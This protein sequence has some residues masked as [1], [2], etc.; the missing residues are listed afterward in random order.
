MT[1]SDPRSE[2]IDTAAPPADPPAAATGAPVTPRRA[3]RRL[4]TAL[5][6]LLLLGLLALLLAAPFSATGTR[7]LLQHLPGLT[8]QE[9]DG[10]LLGDFSAHEVRLVL[11]ARQTLVLRDLGWQGLQWQLS[12]HPQLHLHT[13]QIGLIDLQGQPAQSTPL[14][15][16]QQLELPFGVQIEQIRIDRLQTEALRQQPLQQLQM[17]LQLQSGAAAHHRLDV[18]Q[19]RWERVQVQGHIDLGAAA[20]L[21]L[22]AELALRPALTGPVAAPET[23]AGPPEQPLDQDWQADL[24]ATGTLADFALDAKLQA[25]H[26]QL[27]GVAQIRPELPLPLDRLAL[28]L[29][30]FD[31]SA[32]S[33]A[34][35]QTALTGRISAA[36]PQSAN[37]SGASASSVKGLPLRLQAELENSRAARIDQHG[38]PLRRLQIGLSSSLDQPQAGHIDTFELQL[39]SSTQEAGRWSGRGR[40]ALDGQGATRHLALA[41]DTRIEQLRPDQLDQ[42]APPLQIAGPLALT[43]RE[44]LPKAADQAAGKT[45]A[46]IAPPP[47][48]A[49]PASEPWPPAADFRLDQRAIGI[50]ADLAGRVTSSPWP[51]VRLQLHAAASAGRLLVQQLQA[52]AETARLQ[53]QGRIDHDPQGRWHTGLQ[54]QLRAFDPVLWWPGEP[55]S[56]WR[57]G[58]HRLDGDLKA[59]LVLPA[60]RAPAA[61][62]A[63]GL[64]RLAL[65]Q[66]Q[67]ALT[68]RPSQIAGLPLSGALTLSATA[69]RAPVQTQLDLQLGTDSDIGHLRLDG[70][71]D[72][73][74]RDDRWQ[75]QWQLP[76]LHRLAPWL[77][78]LQDGT[79]PSWQ[80]DSQ[81]ELRLNG[82]W[83]EWRSDGR[84]DSTALQPAPDLNLQAL[85]LRWQA[86]SSAEDPLQLQL[87]L[88]EARHGSRRLTDLNLDVQGRTDAHHLS[89][90]ALLPAPAEP[91]GRPGPLTPLQAELQADGGWISRDSLSGWQ[92]RLQQLM[93]REAA[94]V[95]AASAATPSTP[96]SPLLQAGPAMLRLM[97]TDHAALQAELGSTRL[98]LL[99]A[100]VSLQE[101]RWQRPAGGAPDQLALQATLEPLTVAPLLARAQPGFGWRGNLQVA[102][103]LRM[104]T[105]SSGLHASA[106]LRRHEGDLVVVDPDNPTTPLQRLGLD[107]LNLTLRA[108][109]GLWTLQQRISGSSLGTL[110]GTQTV[111]TDPH[112]L[113][114]TPEARLDGDLDL[115][116]ARLGQWGRW[117]PAGWR[118][119]GRIDS[120]V[121]LGGQLKAPEFSGELHGQQLGVRNVLQGVN[122]HGGELQLRLDGNAATL[123]HFSVQAGDGRL[124]ASGQL[125]LDEN[126]K[127]DLELVAERF[128][129]L[130]RVDRHVS[131]SGRTRLQLDA[132]TLRLSGQLRADAGRIDISRSEAPGLGND[133]EVQRSAAVPSDTDASTPPPA[134]ARRSVIDLDLDLGHRFQ[135]VG[136]GIQTLLTGQLHLDNPDGKLA[137]R[138]DIRTDDGQYA[139]YGQKLVIDRGVISFLGSPDNPRLDIIATR[140]DLD[141]V[142]V[143]VAVSGTAQNPRVRL[144]SEPEMGNTDKLSWLLLGRASDGL[145]R[146]D[147]ALLQRAAYALW[148][149][150]SD[151]PSIVQR[152]G[153]DELSVRQGDGDTRQT[154]VS[155]G[156]QLSRRWYVGYER[157]LNAASGTWQ[158]I[159]RIAQRFT[160]RAQSSESDRALDLIW[161][162]RWTPASEQARAATSAPVVTPAASAASAGGP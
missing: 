33:A 146:T 56:A 54:A 114:P 26:Q 2:A 161:I 141:E 60:A 67:A 27:Q 119:S 96:H 103:Q 121:H 64:D 149:G 158:L 134:S 49:L 136:R 74:Q 53:A 109:A 140:P 63:S 113:W 110:G 108:D 75:L 6:T 47:A 94:T 39:G 20:P 31:L 135:L 123:R 107:E 29:H 52:E 79:P 24:R 25:R 17:A 95:A 90:H 35:P 101:L 153:L 23:F 131:V 62:H 86:G 71:I 10:A 157:N 15:L 19:L 150:E 36:L 22:Q 155:L 66:G 13:L 45:A 117:L 16:P 159:Y 69:P 106:E 120:Q 99:D 70:R 12:P 18:Q 76:G 98:Q 43:L 100:L 142:R 83:P 133:V 124:S 30:D 8:V 137:I 41:L 102:G 112:A 127:A 78:L 111:Q 89:L 105:D 68:L 5:I 40:W 72:T 46:R 147:L 3:G 14:R 115:R 162:W 116:I 4:I 148:A 57:R 65:L 88:K 160:L 126:L 28:N 84:L 143:G 73:V 38:I 130:Q 55:G 7:L 77:A 144:F 9:P 50:K 97:R 156:K 122:W 37:T 118:L 125:T 85:Q 138:G 128:A 104:Q 132:T 48:P 129:A 21:P 80:G 92:G 59:D 87:Q 91:D 154:V 32:F 42:R 145:E 152:I 1:D 81:G 151:S 44:P 58:P 61:P 51:E 139:A 11:D 93:L 82:R 34:L